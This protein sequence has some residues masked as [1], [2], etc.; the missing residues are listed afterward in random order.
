MKYYS[1]YMLKRRNSAYSLHIH[2]DIIMR[3]SGF[4][5]FN[6]RL[7]T[8]G[9]VMYKVSRLAPGSLSGSTFWLAARAGPPAS[10]FRKP[11][12]A[13][14]PISGSSARTKCLAE[15]PFFVAFLEHDPVWQLC[16]VSG[17]GVQ[18]GRNKSGASDSFGGHLSEKIATA[19]GLVSR[20][21]LRFATNRISFRRQRRRSR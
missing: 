15:T 2:D 11:E 7:P 18:Q 4:W 10:P 16:H 20:A 6:F 19:G 13:S 3:F 1:S 9:S 12:S 17:D 5:M 14:G 8:A 21:A